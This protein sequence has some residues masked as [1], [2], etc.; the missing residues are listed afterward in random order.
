MSSESDP[1]RHFGRATAMEVRCL[2]NAVGRRS[3]ECCSFK[4]SWQQMQ[5]SLSLGLTATLGA[6]V[7]VRIAN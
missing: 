3:Q 5:C 4:I 7:P 1:Q 6:L 2:R